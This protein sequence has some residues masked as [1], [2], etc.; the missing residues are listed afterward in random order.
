M[1][2]E[3][4]FRQNPRVALGFS[5][6]VDS[7]YLLYAAVKAGAEI[8]AYYIKTAF[9]P[10]FECE[11]AKGVCR[12]LGVALTVLTMDIMAEPEVVKNSEDRC[13][14]CKRT[15]FGALSNRAK[16]DGY[17]V[18]LDGT[19]ASDDIS[20][21]PGFRVLQ[22]LSVLSPLKECGLTKPAIRSLTKDAG[23]FIWNKPAYACL[24]TRVKDSPLTRKAL[25]RAERAEEIIAT[26][27]FSD[28]RIRTT[29]DEGLMQVTTS[30][31]RQAVE[32]W[33]EINTKLSPLFADGVKLDPKTRKEEAY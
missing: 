2:L 10:E 9:Q 3:T 28:F 29:G 21:R 5:G 17:P 31:Y 18:L 11:D 19:N 14:Y 6:G 12:E 25:Q 4:F 30:Q 13:Y 1:D 15:L 7:S 8:G 23:L 16:A 22:E 32:S 24:A 20:D 27:G 33:D 26:L